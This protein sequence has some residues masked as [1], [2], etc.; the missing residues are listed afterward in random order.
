MKTLFIIRHAKSDKDHSTN[1]DIDRPLNLRGYSDAHAMAEKLNDTRKKPELIISSPAVRA[2]TTALIFARKFRYD[3]KKIILEN[4]LY[5]TGTKEYLKVIGQL[6]NTVS[7]VMLFGHN[8]TITNLVN[9]LTK[10]FTENVPTCG[11]I[12]I[13]FAV[14]NWKDISTGTGKLIL[15]DFPKNAQR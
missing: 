7:S 13:S 6:D 8:S 1:E 9:S 3:P 11:V 14:D 2:L 4:E 5:E 15:Y 12:A 10:P